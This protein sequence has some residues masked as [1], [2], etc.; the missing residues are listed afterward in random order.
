MP[1]VK[2]DWG[3]EGVKY[4]LRDNDIV[5]IVDA[6]RFSSAVA[7]AAAEGFTIYPVSDN[8]KGRALALEIGAEL[9]GEASG[10][11]FSLSPLSYIKN[12]RHPNKRVV[13][14]SP[15]GAACAALL[16]ENDIGYIGCFLNAAAVA[17]RAGRE[18]SES[19]R[20]ITVIAA[21]EERAAEKDGRVY[22]VRENSGRVFAPEDYLGGGAIISYMTLPKD[23]DAILCEST[24]LAVRNRL[25]DLLMESYSGRWLLQNDA[26]KDLEYLLQINYYDI[27]PVIN[28]GKIVNINN[29]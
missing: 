20:D 23:T 12:D 1:T 18:A 5:I 25:R 27:I 29:E 11:G 14:A 7:T 21:G 28:N 4:A 17:R 6:I 13:L 2:L 3:V 16:K 26:Q 15:N 8:E 24:F 9:A 10:T 19:G 22:Y